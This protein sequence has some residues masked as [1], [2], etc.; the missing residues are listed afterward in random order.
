LIDVRQ[1]KLKLLRDSAD[2]PIGWAPAATTAA[3]PMPT[4]TTGCPPPKDKFGGKPFK[5][6]PC[7]Q[8]PCE[9]VL[10]CQ[11]PCGW[12]DDYT[13]TQEKKCDAMGRSPYFCPAT[14]TGPIP[15]TGAPPGTRQGDLPVTV[16]QGATAIQQGAGDIGKQLT[17]MANAMGSM[18]KTL[19]DTFN[20]LFKG[21]TFGKYSTPTPCW[22]NGAVL[23][24]VLWIISKIV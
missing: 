3:A 11:K 6:V 8:I 19:Q 10:D 23:L 4:C 5:N 17:D 9:Y 2:F 15:G 24:M 12:S 22:F 7:N 20:W 16:Q 18:G 13:S 14:V 21:C 1:T